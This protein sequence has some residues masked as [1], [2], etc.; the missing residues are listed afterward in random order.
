MA[1][2]GFENVPCPYTVMVT[3]RHLGL[4]LFRISKRV[5]A[6]KPPNCNDLVSQEEQIYRSIGIVC[7]G[8][9]QW[10]YELSPELQSFAKLLFMNQF[11]VFQGL[12]FPFLRLEL[13]ICT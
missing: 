1:E 5:T 7:P 9:I 8:G 2:N 6:P 12:H 13:R 10:E 11:G 4:N 3:K